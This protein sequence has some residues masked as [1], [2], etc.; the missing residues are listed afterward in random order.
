MVR[1]ADSLAEIKYLSDISEQIPVT[2]IAEFML[3]DGTR[4]EGLIKTRRSGNNAGN[5]RSATLTA[6]YAE[7]TIQNIDGSQHLINYLDVASARDMT[8]AR[9]VDYEKAGL[10]SIVSLPEDKK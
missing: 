6:Y 1:H 9:L 2:G 3:M 7:V 4:I 8:E 5:N 10:Y